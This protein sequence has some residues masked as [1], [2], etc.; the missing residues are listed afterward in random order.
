MA[1]VEI[2]EKKR[3]LWHAQ[4]GRCANC[5]ARRFRHDALGMKD[6]YGECRP[7]MDYGTCEFY[8]EKP[9][10]PKKL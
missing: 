2:P 6:E 4:D 3:C 7:E 1:E 10:P 8:K 9:V 5:K